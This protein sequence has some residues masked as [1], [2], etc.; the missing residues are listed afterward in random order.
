MISIAAK[1]VLP[2]GVDEDD[3]HV[4]RGRR[5]G[6]R[7]LAAGESKSEPA[8]EFDHDFARKAFGYGLREVHPL[9]RARECKR[10]DFLASD[11]DA[12]RHG[13]LRGCARQQ[14]ETDTRARLRRTKNRL[15][16]TARHEA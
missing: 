6:L 10:C 16:G 14:T 7:C 15:P 13:F 12:T 3:K 1:M 5:E 2:Q 8:F 9:A 11:P 4:R